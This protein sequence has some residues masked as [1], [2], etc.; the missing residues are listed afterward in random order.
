MSTATKRPPPPGVVARS[1]SRASATSAT[2]TNGVIPRKKSV[3]GTTSN[4][5]SARAAVKKPSPTSSLAHIPNTSPDDEGEDARAATAAL[6][7]D[8]RERLKKAEL[9]SE[10]YQKQIGVFQSRLDDAIGEQVKLEERLHEEEERAEGLQNEQRESLRQRRELE[11]IYEAERAASMKDKESAQVREEE[12]HGIIQRLKEGMAERETRTGVNDERRLS[13]HSSFQSPVRSSSS[14]SLEPSHFAPPASLQRSNSTN[15]SKL[16]LQ[17]DKVI[18]SLRLELA[19]AQIKLVEMENMGGGRMRELEKIVL[20]TRMTNARLMEEN[21]SFQLLLSE[22]TLNG[23]FTRGDFIRG[24]SR[25]SDSRPASRMGPGTSLADE[26]STVAETDMENQRRLENELNALKE[27]N[28]ALT[29]YINKI[30]GRLLQYQGYEAILDKSDDPVPDK[31]TVPDTSKALPPPPP[32][33]PS[34]LERAKSVAT[35]VNKPRPRPVSY[36]PP[37]SYPASTMSAMSAS[38]TSTTTTDAATAPRI[39]LQR[40]HSH[41]LGGHQ[42]ANSEFVSSAAVVINNMYRPSGTTPTPGPASP[43]IVSPRNS[44]FGPNAA[45]A[46]RIPSGA[47]GA[48]G[49]SNTRS[50]SV[51][52]ASVDEKRM[53]MA[54]NSAVD[55]LSNSNNSDSGIGIDTPSPPRSLASSFDRPGGAVMAGKTI[56]PLRLVQEKSEGDAAE[57]AARAK[58]NRAS[59]ISGWFGRGERSVSEGGTQ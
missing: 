3:Q 41:R 25:G 48:S 10:E 32:T 21:E 30:I 57:A 56:R 18:E 31:Q 28:K 6:M 22:K 24:T 20:E 29:T 9:A 34:L 47:S 15:N 1:P 49:A 2:S 17:K 13:R 4:H 37:P 39:P 23:D 27:Q 7:E 38:D 12:L 42:R 5:V 46:A 16:I 52:R 55:S 26:L 59:W 33:A 36:M 11:G 45:A 50:S 53:S 44:F 8:L 51:P 58:A 35:G 40:S 43:G 14:S 54:S 19:E